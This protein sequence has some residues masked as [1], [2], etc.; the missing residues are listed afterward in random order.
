[1]AKC[2]KL[3]RKVPRKNERVE[4]ARKMYA[5]NRFA[6]VNGLT[7]FEMYQAVVLGYGKV[8]A[9]GLSNDEIRR[10]DVIFKRGGND[11][12][13][14]EVKLLEKAGFLKVG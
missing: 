2:V 5:N 1:M 7:S 4:I 12:T 9:H 10:L 11:C 8:L 3:T 13:S 14:E 6:R